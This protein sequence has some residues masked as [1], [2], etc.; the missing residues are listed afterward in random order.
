MNEGARL[1]RMRLVAVVTGVSVVVAG[2]SAS[3]ALL[4]RQ[5]DRGTAPAASSCEDVA[6]SA[7][8][9][10]R[11]NA[12]EEQRRAVKMRLSD[13]PDV[14]AIAYVSRADTYAQVR[15][16]YRDQPYLLDAISRRTLPASFEVAVSTEEGL[17]RVQDLDAPGVERVLSGFG[18]H[19]GPCAIATSDPHEPPVWSRGRVDRVAAVLRHAECGLRP[20]DFVEPPAIG[21]DKWCSFEVV[22]ENR[23]HHDVTLDESARLLL[24]DEDSTLT[25]STAYV[26]RPRIDDLR[27]E[28]RGTITRTL[29]FAVD[30]LDEPSA[31]VFGTGG[32]AISLSFD[33]DCPGDSTP[34]GPL[35]DFTTE[36]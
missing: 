1:R 18:S 11:R 10:L 20:P 22:F 32:D 5:P 30:P 3:R 2:A 8:V 25:F 29:Y 15:R 21:E 4:D 14:V 16:I 33:Y 13:D 17:Q 19:L 6:G 31:L 24:I 12:T 7:K 23:G 26:E 9:F 28:P 34:V 36:P 27:I 35:C